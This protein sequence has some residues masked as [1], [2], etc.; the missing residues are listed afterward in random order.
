[1][2]HTGLR[3]TN[4]YEFSVYVYKDLFTELGRPGIK[5]TDLFVPSIRNLRENR[6]FRTLNL[7]NNKIMFCFLCDFF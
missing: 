6:D 1:M 3:V 5:G 2:C 4:V 7:W